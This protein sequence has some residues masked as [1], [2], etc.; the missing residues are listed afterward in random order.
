[1]HFHVFQMWSCWTCRNH[2]VS[3]SPLPSWISFRHWQT[4]LRLEVK[5]WELRQAFKWVQVRVYENVSHSIMKNYTF[6]L[7]R[8]K[9][10]ASQS[11][12]W[13]ACLPWWPASVRKWWMYCKGPLLWWT[14]GLFWWIWR[15]QLSWVPLLI[16][17]FVCYGAAL[18]WNLLLASEEKEEKKQERDLS[19]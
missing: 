8:A 19:Q 17:W 10:G 14:K 11:E 9:E 16:T 1:M 5:G 15:G 4:D 7:N 3:R 12:D 13:R 18:L 6:S 2:P